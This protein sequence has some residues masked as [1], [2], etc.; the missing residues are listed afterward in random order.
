MRGRGS[1]RADR[2]PDPC[3]LQVCSNPIINRESSFINSNGFTLI[4]L[5]VV[6][7]IL[8]LLLAILMPVT[9]AA[10]ERGQRVVCLSNLRQ[11]TFAWL[12]YPDEYDGKLVGG[13]AF[14]YTAGQGGGSSPKLRGWVGRAFLLPESRKA[15]FENPDKGALWP[16]LRDTNVYRCPRGRTGHAITYATVVSA[17]ND[18]EVEGTYAPDTGA[19]EMAEVGRRCGVTVLKL[20]R[21]TDIVSPGSAARAVFVDMGQTPF[22]S[23]FYVYYLYPKWGASAPPIRHANGVT[24]S[25]ADA[26]AEYWQWKGDETLR[27]PRK[28]SPLRDTFY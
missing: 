22:S 20:T 7:A 9:R 23:D 14:G 19:R 16:Y 17:N 13:H 11:L 2:W 27:I 15:L 24:L 1:H 12:S 5:L 10:R 25:M 4:E 26:H 28:L 3:G 21:L 18:T 6:I 8:A